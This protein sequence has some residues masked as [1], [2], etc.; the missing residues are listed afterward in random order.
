MET[1]IQVIWWIGLAGALVAT[2]VILKQVS[3]MLRVLRDIH[4]LAKFTRDAS[5]GIAGNLQAVPRLG[6]AAEP[7]FALRD[8]IQ[9]LARTAGAL[10][11]RLAA[12]AAGSSARGELR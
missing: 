11:R 5:R 1:A 4:H 3:L 8:A 7:A 9:A 2:L 10:D 6:G 12:L